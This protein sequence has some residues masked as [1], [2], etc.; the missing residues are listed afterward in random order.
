[1][2]QCDIC[3][4]SFKNGAGLQ[5]HKQFVHEGGEKKYFPKYEVLPFLERLEAKIEPPAE[6]TNT[7]HQ[8]AK[9][10]NET[11]TNLKEVT[12]QLGASNTHIRQEV[13]EIKKGLDTIGQKK[14]NFGWGAAALGALVGFI[15]YPILTKGKEKPTGNAFSQS[16]P[17][18][19]QQI[20]SGYRKPVSLK[21]LGSAFRYPG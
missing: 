14:G 4:K 17:T 21:V 8:V 12:D 19:V 7:M 9:E 6:L 1:M 11:K 20:P 2:V 3:G 10:V 16:S 5:G 15:L 13:E 18:G